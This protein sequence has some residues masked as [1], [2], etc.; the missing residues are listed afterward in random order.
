MEPRI[1][2]GG[3]PKDD[4]DLEAAET[5]LNARYKFKDVAA[6]LQVSEY[7]LR[8]RLREAGSVFRHRLDDQ[9]L[10]QV[11]ED[12]CHVSGHGRAT[13]FRVIQAALSA[14]SGVRVPRSQVLCVQAETD[15]DAH[16]ARRERVIHRRMYDVHEAMVAWHIDSY[17][18]LKMYGFYVHA[19]I[20]GGANF[21]VHALVALDKTSATLLRGYKS[22]VARYGRP[23]RVRADMALEAIPIGADMLDHMGPGAYIAG[24]STSNTKIE[25]FWNFVWSHWAHHAKNVFMQLERSGY[26][27]RED[28]MDPFTLSV[29]FLPELQRTLAEMC[30]DWHYHG[31]RSQPRRGVQGYIPAHVFARGGPY[32]GE[33]PAD[34]HMAAPRSHHPGLLAAERPIH[35]TVY[36][37]SWRSAAYVWKA[38]P[39]TLIG[40]ASA[41]PRHPAW[42]GA[43]VLA[44]RRPSLPRHEEATLDDTYWSRP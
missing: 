32:P 7:V 3:R 33:A 23:L 24:P 15:P 37:F 1:R 34:A 35:A 13:G 43:Y 19:G 2:L 9:E 20:D 5:L 12:T 14:R 11:I 10:A 6:M 39:S 44:S 22:A 38:R 36:R 4:V 28:P 18:K 41:T 29:V 31:V 16:Q 25:N 40:R 21:I 17:E 42:A 8:A 26:L 30:F 27:N